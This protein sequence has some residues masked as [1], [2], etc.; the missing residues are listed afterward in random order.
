MRVRGL[1]QCVFRF[2]GK[3]TCKDVRLKHL[4]PQTQ[5]FS[6]GTDGDDDDNDDGDG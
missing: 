3:E 5:E 6:I 1:G 4:N 2:T